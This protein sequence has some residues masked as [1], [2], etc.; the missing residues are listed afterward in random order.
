M[1]SIRIG[2][3]SVNP[4]LCVQ[5]QIDRCRNKY[6]LHFHSR[7][8]TERWHMVTKRHGREWRSALPPQS[9]TETTQIP[10]TADQITDRSTLHAT[11]W[12]NLTKRQ[13]RKESFTKKF[14][15]VHFTRSERTNKINPCCEKSVL[16]PFV[17]PTVGRCIAKK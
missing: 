10:M 14:C 12:M 6:H 11:T 3:I 1:C 16:S 9:D 17:C 4:W 7:V 5:R 13:F 2:N 15:M 8:Y